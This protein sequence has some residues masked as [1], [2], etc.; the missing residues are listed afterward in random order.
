[1]AICHL[2]CILKDNY[3]SM[4]FLLQFKKKTIVLILGWFSFL[5]GSVRQRAWGKEEQLYVKTLFSCNEFQTWCNAAAIFLLKIEIQINQERKGRKGRWEGRGEE[6]CCVQTSL[7]EWVFQLFTYSHKHSQPFAQYGKINPSR[8]HL[9]QSLK[10]HQSDWSMWADIWQ[11]SPH[12]HQVLCNT[13]TTSASFQAE[14]CNTPKYQ[15]ERGGGRGICSL[16]KPYDLIDKNSY[17]RLAYTSVSSLTE[18]FLP[19]S[20]ICSNP[21]HTIIC[22][23]SI[24]FH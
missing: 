13:N 1:M 17:F 9:S 24:L 11:H 10:L 18:V 14:L 6:F 5:S 15:T 3:N 19:L 20:R 12:S 22:H 21:M 23:P 16:W 8:C 7:S 2:Y 4:L